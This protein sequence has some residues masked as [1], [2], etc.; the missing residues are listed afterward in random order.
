MTA[1]NQILSWICR[2]SKSRLQ[3]LILYSK[4]YYHEE[5]IHL[6]SAGDTEQHDEEQIFPMGPVYDDYDSDPVGEPRGRTRRAAT[7]AVLPL[8]QSLSVSSHRLRSVSLHQ[9]LTH[10]SLPERFNHV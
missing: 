1:T 5:I 4:E 6:R 7:G 9:P 2:I 10:L 8:V 3:S